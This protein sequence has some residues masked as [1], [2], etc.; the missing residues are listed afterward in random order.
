MPYIYPD[1]F[2]RFYDLIYHQQRDGVDN[3]FFLN[4]IK[5]TDGRVLE[6]G[7]GTGRL[8][9]AALNHGTDISGIDISQPMLDVL[10]SK[11]SED[12]RHRISCQNML[13]FSFDKPFK[14]IV[15]PF[16]VFMHLTDKSDQLKALNNVFSHL[17][18]GGRFIFDT[19]IPDFN[20]LMNGMHDVTDFRGEY[21]PGKHISRTINS[22]PDIVNQVL[23]ITFSFKWDEENIT[24]NK[25]WQTKLRYFFRFEL[26]HLAE[27]SYF[28]NCSISGD[29][30]GGALCKDSKDFIVTCVRH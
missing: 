23:D 20:L 28:G 17:D 25:D 26:E 16:R 8:F 18:K 3:D 30:S 21:E 2:A 4:E 10:A 19:F 24:E 7:V 15:A 13:D 29:Y 14:L 5:R 1:F 12:Q 11:L 6:L 9:T 22:I 27:R